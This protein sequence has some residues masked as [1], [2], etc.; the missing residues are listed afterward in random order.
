MNIG[1]TRFQRVSR[2]HR[3][4]SMPGSWRPC[5]RGQWP[6]APPWKSQARRSHSFI[7]LFVS[8]SLAYF[9]GPCSPIFRVHGMPDHGARARAANGLARL[10]AR[11]RRAVR[12][13]FFVYSLPIRW[14]ISPRVSGSPSQSRCNPLKETGF[15]HPLFFSVQI[16]ID[17][18]LSG[19][20]T[21]IEAA[22]R[23]PCPPET[24]SL[25]GIQR[26]TERERLRE[27]GLGDALEA[28]TPGP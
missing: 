11:V 17:A 1:E 23:R 20:Y 28:L 4:H 8:H 7:R 18:L 9:V 14:P 24:S 15:P 22:M 19:T 16:L 6:G 26:R 5:S 21:L 27:I 3:V 25:T 13:R 12:I 10:P 2:D